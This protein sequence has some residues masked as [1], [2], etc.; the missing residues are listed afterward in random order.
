MSSKTAEI[1]WKQTNSK[2]FFLYFLLALK[3]ESYIE[4]DFFWTLPIASLELFFLKDCLFFSIN[5]FSFQLKI[6]SNVS[7][8][9]NIALF[10]LGRQVVSPKYF[11]RFIA[12]EIF[13]GI[14]KIH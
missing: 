5:L 3:E 12:T 2:D 10:I 8:A 14:L 7:R 13:S 9:L 6:I 1:S 4:R 11:N